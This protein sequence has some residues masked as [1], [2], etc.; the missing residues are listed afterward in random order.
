VLD[1]VLPV[2]SLA[3]ERHLVASALVIPVLLVLFWAQG[4][5]DPDHILAGTHEYARI[6]HATTY[7]VLSAL[8][9][10]YF[11]G[12]SPLISRSWLVLVWVLSIGC[13]GCGRAAARLVVHRLRRRGIL[14][15]RVLIVGASTLGV[16]IAEQL[17]AA[18]DEGLD[19]VGFLDE[20]LPL[21][22]PLLGN[23]AVIGR[24]AD[25]VRG[26]AAH[27][28]DEC[29]LVPQALPSQRLEEI[30]RLMASRD[31][32]VLRMA[33]SSS[34]LLTQG[35]LL[36]ERGGVPLLTLPRARRGG[37][38]AALR[39]VPDLVAAMLAR[40]GLASR[41]P[42]SLSRGRFASSNRSPGPVRAWDGAD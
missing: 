23:G 7:G 16:A 40:A 15:A 42:V 12:G 17:R 41:T 6:A 31:G 18:G 13:A 25:L 21:G 32:P 19:P 22:Q 36:V 35:M 4:L 3:T 34:G 38:K 20:Y 5:Y 1:E 33:V 28:A 8:A 27:L 37:P 9:V 29:V 30:S 39:L 10:S 24:P 26:D 2:S 11:A 14:R